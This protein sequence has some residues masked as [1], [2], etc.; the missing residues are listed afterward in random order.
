MGNFLLTAMSGWLGVT[1]FAATLIVPLGITALRIGGPSRRRFMTL[2][3]ILGI[4]LPLVGLTHAALPAGVGDIFARMEPGITYAAAA[5]LLLFIQAGLG[6]YLRGATAARPL[7]RSVHLATMLL[8]AAL[9]TA[10]ILTT[11]A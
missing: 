11:R 6:I 7:L 9:I 8:L 3:F 4:A 2:H 5:L 10:H 1:A